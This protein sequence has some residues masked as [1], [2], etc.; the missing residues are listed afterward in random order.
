[1]S[2]SSKP[3]QW[4]TNTKDASTKIDV[5]LDGE[6]LETALSS[7][8]GESKELDLPP[9]VKEML[10]QTTMRTILFQISANY[11][12]EMKA[13]LGE[14]KLDEDGNIIALMEGSIPKELYAFI[15]EKI[16]G[17]V[18]PIEFEITDSGNE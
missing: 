1:M 18:P 7:L 17:Y 16:I 12:E 4:E 9:E 10:I 5:H 15:C 11:K 13:L 8:E 3:E 2:D 6:V 14:D